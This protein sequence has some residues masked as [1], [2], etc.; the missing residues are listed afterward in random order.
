M[1]NLMKRSLLIITF[2]TVSISMANNND[3]GIKVNLIENKLIQLT[4]SGDSDVFEISVRDNYGVL[5]HKENL[6]SDNNSKKYDLA[7]LPNGNYFMEIES[8]TK[9]KV[10]PFKVSAKSVA[11]K[12]DDEIIHFKPTIRKTEDIVYVSMLAL[13]NEKLEVLLYDMNNNLLYSETLQDKEI[14]E[15]KLNL[16]NLKSGS[17]SMILRSNGKAFYETIKI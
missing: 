15:R 1:K 4:L 17:Y 2:F 7:N 8:S 13:N 3:P 10:I 14:L 12:N 11:L 16:M 5:L 6:Q 9:I